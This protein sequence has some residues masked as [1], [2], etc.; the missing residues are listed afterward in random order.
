MR[1][2][3]ANNMTFKAIWEVHA[4][5]LTVGIIGTGTSN[6]TGKSRVKTNV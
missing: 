6:I 1:A 2:S 3:E 5:A 4:I